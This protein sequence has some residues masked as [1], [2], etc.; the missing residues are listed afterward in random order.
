MPIALVVLPVDAAQAP[1]AG[2]VHQFD[3]SRGAKLDGG[4]LW[5]ER[6][7]PVGYWRLTNPEVRGS[8]GRLSGH[9]LG[10]PEQEQRHHD[11]REGEQTPPR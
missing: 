1:A 5:R 4:R 2:A 9:R 3:G 10:S 7:P 11:G 8:Q 6:R